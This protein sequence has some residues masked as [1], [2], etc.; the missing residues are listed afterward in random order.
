MRVASSVHAAIGAYL[1]THIDTKRQNLVSLGKCPKVGRLALP[2]VND[3]L[4][5]QH[6]IDQRLQ[7]FVLHH[8]GKPVS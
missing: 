1:H 6:S 8:S 3:T 2:D 7:L 5:T 4:P